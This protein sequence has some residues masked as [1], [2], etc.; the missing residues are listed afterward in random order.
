M[1]LVALARPESLERARADGLEVA[2][3]KEGFF[4]DCDVLSLHMRLVPATH[5][6]VFAVSSGPRI[7]GIPGQSWSSTSRSLRA[8]A[9]GW[10]A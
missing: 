8:K 6:I 7:P 2:S 5:G 1:Q 4:A 3:S 10:P 9:S